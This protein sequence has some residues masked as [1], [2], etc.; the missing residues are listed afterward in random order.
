MHSLNNAS[1]LPSIWPL[2]WLLAAAPPRSPITSRATTKAPGRRFCRPSDSPPAPVDLRI[3]SCS[4][5]A[6]PRLRRQWI[7]RVSSAAHSSSSKASR[8]SRRRS[9][10]SRPQKRVVVRSIVDS[11]CSEACAS[12]GRRRSTSAFSRSRKTPLFS[13]ASVGT[14]AP[15]MAAVHRGS[16]AALWIAVVARQRKATSA[17]RTCCRPRTISASKPPFQSRR[18]W[19]FFDSAYRSRVD[20]DYFADA[21]ARPASARCTSPAGTTSKPTPRPTR[22]CASLI[23]ACHR[24]GILVYVWLELPHVSEKFW[25]DHPEWR[26]KTALLQDAQLDWRKLMNL[27]ESRLP[28]RPSAPA[29]RL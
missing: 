6:A 13:P 24:H 21:G 19:A 4:A 7:D 8:N 28:S 23:E 1:P 22:T 9:A 20:L 10:S 29:S 11:A 16:G 17:S 12:S 27:H 15:V 14:G 3:C 2:P 18:L 26:E 5:A 25:A